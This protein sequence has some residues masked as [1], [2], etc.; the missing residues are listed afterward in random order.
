MGFPGTHT[1]DYCLSMIQIITFALGI[2][3]VLNAGSLT[4][5]KLIFFRMRPVVHKAAV[6]S[7]C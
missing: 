7:I 3:V 2:S 6:K 4:D 5:E 1:I